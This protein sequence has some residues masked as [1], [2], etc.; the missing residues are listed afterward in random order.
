MKKNRR[1]ATEEKIKYQRGKMSSSFY[2]NGFPERER[3][4]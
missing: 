4:E 2:V 3:E 1:K